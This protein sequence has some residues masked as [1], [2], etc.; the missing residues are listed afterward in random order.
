MKRILFPLLLVF[1]GVGVQAQ[2]ATA[3]FVKGNQLFDQKNYVAAADAFTKCISYD[4]SHAGCYMNRGLARQIDIG[5]GLALED[6]TKLISI[7]PASWRRL[8]F[9]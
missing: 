9:A 5:Y 2:N 8:Q 1:L 3:E 6:F 4:P 7:R